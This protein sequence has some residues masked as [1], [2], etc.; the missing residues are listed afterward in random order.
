MEIQGN[1]DY[2]IYKDGS[3]W[4]KKT[5]KFMVGS[6]DTDGYRQVKLGY[7]SR[8]DTKTWK[9][10]RLIAIHYI[11]NDDENKT[12]VDHI[13]RNRLDN[14]LENLRWATMSEQNLNRGIPKNNNSGISNISYKNKGGLWV[15]KKIINGDK[16]EVSSKNKNIILWTKFVFSIITR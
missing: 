1:S 11:P 3:V 5:N 12:T 2:L 7:G 9:R 8:K 16:F 14:R 4:S 10:H 13:N 6:L 15:F